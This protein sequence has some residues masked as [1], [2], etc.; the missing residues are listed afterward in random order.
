MLAFALGFPIIT[1]AIPMVTMRDVAL[2][3]GVS[4]PTVSFV[5]GQQPAS[6]HISEAT[7]QRVL[8]AVRQLGYRHNEVARSVARG[9]TSVVDFILRWPDSEYAA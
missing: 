2:K 6:V 5:L 9:K 4:R 3:A 1:R 8:D 7:R